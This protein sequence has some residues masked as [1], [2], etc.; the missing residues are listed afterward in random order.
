MKKR[1]FVASGSG[2]GFA[3]KEL[4]VF[5][6]QV[7]LRDTGVVWPPRKGLGGASSAHAPAQPESWSSTTSP[8]KP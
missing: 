2:L 6:E 4:C 5:F 1:S 3:K 8:P 7:R